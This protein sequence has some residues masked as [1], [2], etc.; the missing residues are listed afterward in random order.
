MRNWR[1][2]LLL[3]TTTHCRDV[4]V[5][6]LACCVCSRREE[7]IAGKTLQATPLRGETLHQLYQTTDGNPRRTLGDPGLGIVH[8]G[9]AGNVEVQ[10]GRVEGEFVEEHRCAA[11][12]APAPA[13][14]HQIRD[15]RAHGFQIVFAERQAPELLAGLVNGLAKAL[16]DGVVI[17]ENPSVRVAKRNN[18]GS[19]ERGGV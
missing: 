7:D 17:R 6:R 10:P 8:P 13:G 11:R 4:S 5:L 19:G 18:D 16:V 14:V 2:R 12:A 1:D 3:A 15:V 9:S